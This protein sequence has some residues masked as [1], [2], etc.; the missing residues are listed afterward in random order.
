MEAAE[1]RE[2]AGKHT[3]NCMRS[4]GVRVYGEAPLK[5][6]TKKR[7]R[8]REVYLAVRASRQ[9]LRALRLRRVDSDSVF[10]LLAARRGDLRQVRLQ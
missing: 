1:G 4:H 6:K 2:K 3:E 7:I 9:A 8:K 10:R 5:C